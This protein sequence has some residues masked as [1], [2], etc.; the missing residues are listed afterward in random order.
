[1]AQ[2]MKQTLVFGASAIGLAA[3]IQGASA[4]TETKSMTLAEVKAEN[5][6]RIAAYESEKREIDE[7]NRVKRAQYRDAYAHYA[8]F[9]NRGEAEPK[10]PEYEALPTLELLDEPIELPFD[11]VGATPHESTFMSE[12][13]NNVAIPE[14]SSATVSENDKTEDDTPSGT[15]VAELHETT[16]KSDTLSNVAISEVNETTEKLSSDGKV[17]EPETHSTKTKEAGAKEKA[18]D[19]TT[20]ETKETGEKTSSDTTTSETKETGEKTSLNAKASETKE[21]GEKTSSDAV[22]AQLNGEK[23]SSDAVAA[24]LNKESEKTTTSSSDAAAQVSKIESE[25]ASTATKSDAPAETTS[26]TDASTKVAKLEAEKLTTT[27]S[28]EVT[29]ATTVKSDANPKKTDDVGKTNTNG[30]TQARNL[31]NTTANTSKSESTTKDKGQES[32]PHTGDSGGL[33]S[34][35]GAA[36]SGIGAVSLRRKRK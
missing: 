1:M 20:S 24:Q 22:A 26:S 11:V 32:L 12:H 33:V 31:S 35:M 18:S 14:S 3:L 25:K 36:L 21:T 10:A 34:L 4:D 30:N 6:K 7:R 2:L 13:N 8:E 16:E 28:D 15:V 19:A 29:P 27:K 5:A 23:T 17:S 9:A